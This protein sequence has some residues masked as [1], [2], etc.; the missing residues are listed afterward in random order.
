MPRVAVVTDSTADLP[1]EMIEAYDIHVVPLTV[2]IDGEV[3]EDGVSI[4][5]AEFMRRLTTTT[6]F[7]TTSQP[8]VGRFQEVF[9]RLAEE[10][11]AIISIHISSRL[12]GTY[13][14]ALLAR[15]TIN[16]RLPISVIDSRSTS[17][18]LGFPVLRAAK[19][20][21]AGYDLDTID[22][23]TRQA[24]ESTHAVFLVD[25]LEYLRRGGR[26]GRA[27]EI[28]GTV[29]QLKPILRL[30]EGVVVP[31]ARTRTRPKA[32]AGLI[33]LVRD[34]PRIDQLAILTTN[35][36]S[37][38]ERVADALADRC[39]RERMIFAEL[40]P[41]LAAHVGPGAL[42]VVVYEGDAPLSIEEVP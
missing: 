7:P 1:R 9:N 21:Q 5:P 2:H 27:A 17:M 38:A 34:F 16:G 10:Y 42:G 13:Q 18:G 31:H 37:D 30:E 36:S 15:D 19:L 35:G 8:S 24:I 39:P 23:A 33:E 6:T 28:V 41:V 40:S 14:S 29:L 25:T 22:R 20:A 26:I 3:F 11:D 12:S 4:T 32:T